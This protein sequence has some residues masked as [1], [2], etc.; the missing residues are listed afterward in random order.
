MADLNPEQ[1]EVVRHRNS[2]L[3]VFAAAGTGKTHALASRIASIIRDDH[4]DPSRILAVTF[5]N[6]AAKEMQRR[7]VSMLGADDSNKYKRLRIGTFHS[8]CLSLL[9]EHPLDTSLG[10]SFSIVEPGEA[11]KRLERVVD[12]AVDLAGR[13]GWASPVKVD[14][15]ALQRCI[16]EHYR[17]AGHEPPTLPL[18][19]AGR[20]EMSDLAGIAYRLYRD[21]CVADA[22][23]DFDDLIMHALALLERRPDIAAKF[24]HVLVDEFQDT[25]IAQMRFV[26][27]IAAR[28]ELMVVGDDYQAIHEWRGATIRNILEFEA[29]T[30]GTRVVKL[31]RNY[32]SR[33]RIL[34][35]AQSTI[36]HNE[37][38][39]RKR[40]VPMRPTAGLTCVKRWRPWNEQT[41]AAKAVAIALEMPVGERLAVLYRSHNRAAP[42]EEAFRVAGV[43]YTVS[44][45][46]AFFERKEIS[47]MVGYLG[48][49]LSD[50]RG[51]EQ[52]I[53]VPPRGIGPKTLAELLSGEGGLW[54]ACVQAKTE[55][56][57][58]FV[59]DIGRI[60]RAATELAS[61]PRAAVATVF[62][63]S[64]YKRHLEDAQEGARVE[65]VTELVEMAGR[66]A[67]LSEFYDLCKLHADTDSEVAAPV[68]LMTIHASK[69][70]EFEHV[71]VA[72]CVEGVFPDSR[73]RIEEERRLC[74]VAMTRARDVLHLS[75]P[76]KVSGVHVPHGARGAHPSPFFIGA[77]G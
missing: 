77:A 64:G 67:T 52:I 5:T 46:T 66:S 23:T 55:K 51:L 3:L 60:S 21:R 72:G 75:A 65:N 28:A 76:T 16:A 2:P 53:N 36:D 63:L 32:R 27:M 58:S 38:Q 45:S 34:D 7:V 4:V 22:C 41:E 10:D 40:L 11:S 26:R 8:V 50:R 48:A 35:V 49:A 57:R 14:V 1:L 17:N 43:P 6:K 42:F 15:G 20:R 9:R 73:S 18:N 19:L 74:Y 59:A 30:P 70:L 33:P 71:F 47:V 37:A 31:V 25:N 24:D 69:G 62:E 61:D 29:T 44:K 13:Y 68:Q 12:E 54:Q 39:V 56:V